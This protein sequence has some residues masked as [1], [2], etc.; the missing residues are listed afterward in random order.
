[1]IEMLQEAIIV[2]D[3]AEIKDFDALAQLKRISWVKNV[4]TESRGFGIF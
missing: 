4:R 2:Y 1:M 3:N